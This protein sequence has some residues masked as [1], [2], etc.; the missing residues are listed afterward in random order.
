MEPHQH[1]C[2]QTEQTIRS[3]EFQ[4]YGTVLNGTMAQR[5]RWKRV[6]DEEEN[7]IGFML[8]ELYVER[9]YSPEVKARYDQM[10]DNVVA[11]YRERIDKLDWMTDATKQKAQQK[12]GT[13]MKKVGYPDKW[14]DYSTLV[15]DK[16]SYAENVM[17][18]TRWY[19]EYEISKL[20]KPVDRNEWEMTLKRGMHT[21]IHRTMRS[22][23]LPLPSSF[24]AW[25]TPAWMMP[26]CMAMQQVLPS[27]MRLP[28]ALMIRAVSL[29]RR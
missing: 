3:A 24:P 21:I 5:P 22:C 10:V 23:Y 20:G 19:H 16:S 18:A 29:M 28:M 11:A 15:I 14:R 6:L 2:R 26:S 17:R 12:L 7:L 9:F 13:V 27:A 1:L 25:Q 4:F 8:G